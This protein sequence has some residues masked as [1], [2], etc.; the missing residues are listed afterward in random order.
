VPTI[1]IVD[2]DAFQRTMLV[3]FIS[4]RLKMDCLEA[5][6]GAEALACLRKDKN[7]DI[8]AIL[9]DLAMPVMDGRTVLP[10]FLSI[11]PDLPVIVVTASQSLNEAVDVMK[12]GATDFLPKPPDPELLGLTI[13]KALR[14]HS[15]RH[16]IK[17]LRDE[18]SKV[19]KFSTLV[20]EDPG[21]HT[22]IKLGKKAAT[23]DITVLITGESGVGKEVFARAI[24]EESDRAALPFVAV[25][26]GAIPKDLVESILFGHK[27]G[28]FTGAIADAPGK[29]REAEGG[30]LFLDEVGELPLEAQVKL[31]R[32]LQQREIEPVG[33]N[34][35]VPVNIRVIAATNRDPVAAV[36]HGHFREDLFYRLNAF[37][38]HIPPL[39]Q[40]PKDIL[41]LA[42]YFLQRIAA[43][44]KKNVEGFDA[45]AQQWLAAHSWLGNVR[46]LENKIFRAVLLCD[47]KEIRVEHLLPV[48]PPF[49]I[50]NDQASEIGALEQKSTLQISL[51]DGSTGQFK[52]MEQIKEEAVQAA[53][54]F[55]QNNITHAAQQLGLGKSTIYRFIKV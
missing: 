30:T 50:A 42:L 7:E 39:R 48:Q 31:L 12:L 1:L 52:S 23:S 43:M 21:L 46:E 34:R 36:K 32:A 41:A 9:L 2:D 4:Q 51:L 40:R 18:Q 6:N 35:P 33:E 47:E 24:H 3:K 44:E 14:V 15:L 17:N 20:G 28:S 54:Q 5:A 37:P 49:I 8:A 45:D 53:L 27:K 19:S 11:R 29:F 22:C 16:E 13:A 55:S 25:N 26:C 38:I 10:Q